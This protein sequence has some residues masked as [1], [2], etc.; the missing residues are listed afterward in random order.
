MHILKVHILIYSGSVSVDDKKNDDQIL[1][2]GDIIVE[3]ELLVY[4]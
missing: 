1:K 2:V 3:H 4:K